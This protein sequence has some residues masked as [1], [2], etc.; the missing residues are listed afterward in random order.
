MIAR[1][2]KFIPCNTDSVLMINDGEATRIAIRDKNVAVVSAL[3][4]VIDWVSDVVLHEGNY[5]S[6]KDFALNLVR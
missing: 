2:Y 6:C 3:Y 1:N 4:V 5:S